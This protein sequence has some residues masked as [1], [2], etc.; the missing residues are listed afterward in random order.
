MSTWE[1]GKLMIFGKIQKKNYMWNEKFEEENKSKSI[2]LPAAICF[3]RFRALPALNQ[4]ICCSLNVWFSL[5]LSTLPSACLISQSTGL[6]GDNLAKPRIEI[7]SVG[8]TCRSNYEKKKLFSSTSN[9]FQL[10]FNHSNLPYRNQ[11]DWQMWVATCLA[12]SNLFHG[13]V[14]MI[15]WW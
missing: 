3:M 8:C 4:S 14:Q 11:M 13:Y 9:P 12:F 7:L 6:P 1:I 10:D 5:I 15:L 2:Y